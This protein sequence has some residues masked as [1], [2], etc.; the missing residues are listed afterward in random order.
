MLWVQSAIAKAAEYLGRNDPRVS[1]IP[2]SLAESLQDVARDEMLL[3]GEV[4]KKC[5][6]W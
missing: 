3:P 1:G 5:I 2:H 6:L 4:Y